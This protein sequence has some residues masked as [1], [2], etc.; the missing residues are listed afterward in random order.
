MHYSIDNAGGSRQ[1]RN[2]NL[3]GK[4]TNHSMIL[5]LKSVIRS[6]IEISF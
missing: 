2:V 1:N 4:H 3:K 6:V 5:N